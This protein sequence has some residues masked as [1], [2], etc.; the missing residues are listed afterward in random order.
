MS[1]Q[2]SITEFLRIRHKLKK[3]LFLWKWYRIVGPLMIGLSLCT[4]FYETAKSCV[5]SLRPHFFAV[6]RPSI[7]LM[8]CTNKYMYI[9]DYNCTAPENDLLIDSRQA[10][11]W[12]DKIYSVK[13]KVM[14]ILLFHHVIYT[15]ILAHLLLCSR[16]NFTKAR[17]ASR[18]QGLSQA[19]VPGDL[20]QISI[21]VGA[22]RS[23]SRY[24]SDLNLEICTTKDK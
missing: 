4:L 13:K 19:L 17:A 7:D 11:S 20:L 22:H 5:G 14:V 24:V 6:C 12:S 10:T 23:F 1:F 21:F 8:N 16:T 3:K 9:T 18:L 2:I 15:V